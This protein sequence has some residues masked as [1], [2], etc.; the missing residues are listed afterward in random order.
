QMDG[1]LDVRSQSEADSMLTVTLTRFDLQ[2]LAFNRRQG[3][4][5]EEYRITLTGRVVFSN[6]KTG[7]VIHENPAVTGDSDFPFMADLTASKRAALPTAASDLARKAI[8]LT[9]TG[10]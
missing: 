4:L 6:A 3:S 1:R 7:E 9:V 8:S 2:A 10:W 5:A